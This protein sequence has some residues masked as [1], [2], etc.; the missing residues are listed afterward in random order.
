MAKSRSPNSSRLLASGAARNSAISSADLVIH[1]FD[2]WPVEADLR[3]LGLQ[4]QRPGQAGQGKRNASQ[5]PAF[6]W[7]SAFLGLHVLPEAL[8]QLGG[9]GLLVTE[10][11]G[12]AADH[13]GIDRLDHV[14]ESEA[15]FLLR[16]LRVVDG[17][18]QEIAK[19]LAK[20][21]ARSPG[22]GIRHLI[23]FLDRVGR[24]GLESL[25][26]VPRAAV[27][28]VRRAFMMARR[29]SMRRGSMSGGL[30]MRMHLADLAGRGY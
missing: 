24:N 1:I 3:R 29:V 12:M 6:G 28:G 15:A 5:Q 25:L 17:L 22:D 11:M 2:A 10:Y 30:V 18:Q 9:A 16:H 8:G 23:G 20:F 7:P 19:F 27:T 13:L 21:G 14:V 4:L 26:E